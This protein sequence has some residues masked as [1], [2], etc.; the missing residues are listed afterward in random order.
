MRAIATVVFLF[1]TSMLAACSDD[2]SRP[3]AS[4]SGG[5]SG[6]VAP[7]PPPTGTDG[8]AATDAGDDPDA[9]GVAMHAS[10]DEVQELAITSEPPPAL[11]GT[12]S[13]GTYALSEMNAYVGEETT[14]PAGPGGG[15]TGTTGRGTIVIAGTRMRV[16]RARTGGDAGAQTEEGSYAFEVKGATLH[17]TKTCASA[18]D[19]R[20]LPFTATPSGFALF[21]DGRHRELYVRTATP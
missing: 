5:T 17:K 1:S 9:C 19:E 21:V 3:A 10:A 18:T 13:A 14:P 2:P 16:L 11:G 15:L 6:T 4:T 7:P 20:P 8:G 12:L